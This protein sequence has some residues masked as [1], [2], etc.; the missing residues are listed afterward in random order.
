MQFNVMHF[1]K[2]QQAGHASIVDTGT[3]DPEKDALLYAVTMPVFDPAT[4]QRIEDQVF[5][6][7]HRDLVSHRDRLQ[8]ELDELNTLLEEVEAQA[9]PGKHIRDVGKSQTESAQ[10]QEQS[11]G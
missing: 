10:S 1:R 6:V 3:F 7:Y 4:G 11:N 5:G 2:Q 9:A 8:E